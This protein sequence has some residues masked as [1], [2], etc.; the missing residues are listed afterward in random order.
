[1]PPCA[2]ICLIYILPFYEVPAVQLSLQF[3]RFDRRD[4]VFSLT[5]LLTL[6]LHCSFTESFVFCECIYLIQSTLWLDKGRGGHSG[7]MQLSS[8]DHRVQFLNSGSISIVV[9]LAFRKK[10]NCDL[11][12]WVHKV[13]CTSLDLTP[14][15]PA[16]FTEW[17]NSWSSDLMLQARFQYFNA[18]ISACEPSICFSVCLASCHTVVL[19]P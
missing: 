12:R 16:H 10:G 18:E 14:N 5:S 2:L 9:L 17:L 1:M 15:N 4:A 19:T 7:C 13:T 3:L 6:P 11:R 8:S